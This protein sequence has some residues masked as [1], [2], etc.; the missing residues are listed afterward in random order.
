[1]RESFQARLAELD[2]KKRTAELVEARD[3]AHEAKSLGRELRDA[4]L[5][6]CQRIGPEVA[7]ISDP[8]KCTDTLVRAMTAA[9]AKIVH[10]G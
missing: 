8:R 10:E 7:S 2:Y 3:V 9:L 4:I 6:A 1:V 5:N